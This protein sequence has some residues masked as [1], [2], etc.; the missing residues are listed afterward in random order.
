MSFASP[1]LLAALLLVPVA[2][3]LLHRG[4]RRA[5][6][7]AIRFTGV[8][9]LAA[10]MA[11]EPRRRRLVPSALFLL[12]LTALALAL[13]RPHATVAVPVERASV[14][15]VTDVSLSMIADDIEPSRLGA[16]A[17]A[18]QRFLDQVPDGL[19]VGSVTFSGEAQTVDSPSTDH[20]AARNVLDS[21]V[22]DGGT[23]TGDGLAAALDLLAD[24]EATGDSA[25]RA[26]APAAIVL[27]S[28]GKATL[29][30]DPLEVARE[31]GRLDVPVYTVALGTATEV[32]EAP[33][34]SLIPVPPDPEALRDIARASGGRAF[35]A[36]ESGEL[37][38]VYERLGS[39][40]GTR[41][42]EREIT[43]GFAGAGALAL[44]L[45]AGLS[46]RWSGRLP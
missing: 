10:V 30:R 22:A 7:H 3:L 40:L 16:A 43:A 15:L 21:L 29:G 9:T 12:A 38:A 11:P 17:R 41:D 46:L 45:A 37:D 20:D 5:P 32:I 42:A 6:R 36:D 23:A 19:R 44:L 26:R 33:D 35:E 14:V 24:E 34:G 39:Q 8:A 27:L 31:A 25:P 4:G 28:D 2:M 1:A 18:G 13:A